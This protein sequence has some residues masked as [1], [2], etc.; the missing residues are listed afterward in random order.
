MTRTAWLVLCLASAALAGQARAQEP[1]VLPTLPFAPPAPTSPGPSVAASPTAPDD[2]RDAWRQA[3]K[4]NSTSSGD[5]GALTCKVEATPTPDWNEPLSRS[6]WQADQAWRYSLMGPVTVF[7]QLGAN[8]AE[9]AQADMKV[10]GRTGLACKVPFGALAEFTVRG[11]PGVTYTDPLRPERAREQPNWL[12]EV[13]ARCPWLYGVG[14]EYQTIAVPAMSPLEH[15]QV[16]QDL[17]LA[18]PVG[19]AGQVQLGAKH[20]WENTPDP[21]QAPDSMQFYFGFRL[22][23]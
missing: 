3:I 13:Q 8:S 20:H 15:G 9:P 14:V 23:R 2:P 18:V 21:R 6:T 10:A 1:F 22:T 19:S 5:W 4:V 16:N 11:G 17:H 12:L 7:G